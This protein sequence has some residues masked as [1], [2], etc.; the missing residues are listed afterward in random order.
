MSE[1]AGW[2]LQLNLEVCC[3]DVRCT[4][5]LYAV[6]MC[7][8]L[9]EGTVC[10]TNVP[11]AHRR[12]CAERVL[13]N[14]AWASTSVDVRGIVMLVYCTVLF[15]VLYDVYRVRCSHCPYVTQP[16]VTDPS[17]ATY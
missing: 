11:Y 4:N 3:P 1:F 14:V 7:C 2:L 17:P 8:M 5:V 16:T 9:Y 13:N 12:L 6:R 15:T 10:C